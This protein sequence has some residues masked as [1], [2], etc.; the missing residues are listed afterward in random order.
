MANDNI[1]KAFYNGIAVILVFVIISSV[2]IRQADKSRSELMV[3]G[4]I[5]TFEFTERTGKPFG[6]DNMLG[7][8]CI[9]DFIF[10]NCPS[11]CPIMADK[12]VEL[13]QLYDHSDKVKFVSITVDPNRDTLETL[14]NYAKLHGVNDYRWLFLRAPIED[15]VELSEK[16]FFL[17]AENLPMGHSSKFALVDH[18]GNIRGYYNALEQAL[19]ELLKTHVKALAKKI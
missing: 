1:I 11:A 10:T 12:M 16:G 6:S 14:Q 2:I 8:I 15:V 3:Y 4:K 9:V 17:P 7:S 13:Y 19:I 5:P 18:E